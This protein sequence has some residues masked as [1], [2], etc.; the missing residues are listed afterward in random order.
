MPYNPNPQHTRILGNGRVRYLY[1]REEMA[2]MSRGFDV[3]RELNHE[4]RHL[5]SICF[6]V[7]TKR[8]KTTL[9][10]DVYEYKR[11]GNYV[12]FAKAGDDLTQRLEMFERI[13]RKG[14]LFTRTKQDIHESQKAILQEQPI[15]ESALLIQC[16]RKSAHQFPTETHADI[17]EAS[18]RAELNMQHLRVMGASRKPN[19]RFIGGK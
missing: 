14:F 13:Q 16:A 2:E 15:T 10:R 17:Y 1:T 9:Q 19:K 8:G 5:S 12:L 3:L 11:D 4:Y 7:V 18:I 6:V